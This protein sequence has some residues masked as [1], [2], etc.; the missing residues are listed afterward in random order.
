M[1]HD[2]IVVGLMSGTSADGI[3]ACVTRLRLESGRIRP[4]L[5]FEILH[6]ETTPYPS[7]L[8]KAVLSVSS[9]EDVC[10]LNAAV[11][12]AFAS[13]AL[14]A[15]R[16]SRVKKD[17]IL[18]VSSHGQTLWHAPRLSAASRHGR[19]CRWATSRSLPPVR[20]FGASATSAQ[21][22]L[23]S[24]DRARPLCRSSNGC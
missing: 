21:R 14:E 24:V 7:A 16:Q 11:G 4:R 5:S 22:T 2:G 8:R 3:D 12:E 13:A 15:I 18:A 19:P 17:G 6:C 20:G 23:P 1:P 10:R 9:V